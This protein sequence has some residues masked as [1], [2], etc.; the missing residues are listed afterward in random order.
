M[1]VMYER[2][3]KGSRYVCYHPWQVVGVCVAVANKKHME[4]LPGRCLPI[5][6]AGKG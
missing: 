5:A 6:D 3:A 4:L 2:I 1:L